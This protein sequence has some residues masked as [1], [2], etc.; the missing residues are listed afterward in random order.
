MP[1]NSTATSAVPTTPAEDK[2]AADRAA[3]RANSKY[4]GTVDEDV[5]LDVRVNHIG[6]PFPSNYGKGDRFLFLLGDTD[7]NAIRVWNTGKSFEGPGGLTV[8]PNKGDRFQLRGTVKK[9]EERDGEKRTE[10]KNVSIVK[11]L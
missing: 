8:T 4:V 1:R 3:M 10:L 2:L 6:G 5:T 9:Q 7:R 11:A